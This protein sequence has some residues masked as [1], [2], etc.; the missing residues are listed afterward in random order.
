MPTLSGLDSAAIQLLRAKL[1]AIPDVESVVIDETHGVIHLLCEPQAPV[2][3]IQR[4]AHD[5][6]G[7][8][9]LH[10]GSV[11]LELVMRASGVPRQ[12]VR[13]LSAE[14]MMDPDHRVRVRVALEW[15]GQIC[16]GESI[17]ENGEFIELRTAALAA[18]NAIEKVVGE[19]LG[20]KVIGVKQVRAFD[21]DLM[22]VSMHRSNSTPQRLV[23][24]V[25][26]GRDPR[27]SAAIAVLNGLNRTLGNYLNVG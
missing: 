9:S 19:P 10:E 13:F 18:L 8:L 4:I 7:T 26:G 2:M 25:P 3:P 1:E 14:R 22:V 20:V 21:S 6:L 11:S 27:E 12:R 23:G 16:T 15:H 17:G 24:A 5:A